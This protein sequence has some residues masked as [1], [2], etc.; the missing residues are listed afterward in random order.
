MKSDED[1]RMAGDIDWV[2][3][4]AN[5]RSAVVSALL[6]DQG[7]RRMIVGAADCWSGARRGQQ[8]GSGLAGAW[9]MK[10]SSVYIAEER[11][12]RS[13]VIKVPKARSH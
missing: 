13:G 1:P 12:S 8:A 9:R 4:T 3:S 5:V 2:C 6:P 10:A 11:W 7:L